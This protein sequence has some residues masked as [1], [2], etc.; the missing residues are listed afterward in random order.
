M[1]LSG[2]DAPENVNPLPEIDP[3]LIVSAAVPLDVIVTA[4]VAELPV[5][6]SPN[7]RLEGLTVIPAVPAAFN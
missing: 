5:T 3:E 6:T 1:R 2:N 4:C 7:D